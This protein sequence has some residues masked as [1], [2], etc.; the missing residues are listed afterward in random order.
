MDGWYSLGWQ[1]SE[2]RGQRWGMEKV[3]RRS[4]GIPGKG[5]TGFS[6]R[7]WDFKPAKKRSGG[8]HGRLSHDAEFFRAAALGSWRRVL[9]ACRMAMCRWHAA[10]P[11]VVGMLH[12]HVSL[13]CC[14]AMC[15]WHAAWPCVAG[16]LHGHVLFAC[17]MAICRWHAAWPCVVGMLHGHV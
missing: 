8:K 14:M 15:C 5:G 13:A 1:S 2:A 12:G 7:V 3:T 11:C 9:R 17:C 6:G 4:E 16:M 10:W